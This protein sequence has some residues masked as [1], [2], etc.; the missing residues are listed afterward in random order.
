MM[1]NYE[2]YKEQIEWITR[3][4]KEYKKWSNIQENL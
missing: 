1:T 4:E 3:L 2:H